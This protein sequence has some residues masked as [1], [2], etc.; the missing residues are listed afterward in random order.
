[1]LWSADRPFKISLY[2]IF[3]IG[4]TVYRMEFEIRD[5]DE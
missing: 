3:N 5:K 1:M 4:Y 2:T